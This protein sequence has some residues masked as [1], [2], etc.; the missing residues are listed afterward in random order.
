MYI[1]SRLI[2]AG[3]NALMDW[4]HL[5][6]AISILLAAASLLVILI[7]L[8]VG[9]YQRMAIMNVVWPLTA[10]YGGPLAVLAYYKI[11]RLSTHKA[12]AHTGR[13]KEKK[14]FWQSVVVGVTHCGSGCTLGDL[15]AEWFVLAVPITF[16]GQKLFGSWL[17]DFALAFLFGIAFQY[18]SIKP[19]RNLSLSQGL[20]AAIKADALS[21]ASWQA[22]MYGWMAFAIFRIFGH[23]LAK[24]DTVFWFMMQIAMLVGFATAFPVNWWLIKA[25]IKEE[26]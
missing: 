25:G 21:L 12:Q 15:I 3:D 8:L 18:F 4:L 17:L 13:R 7:D 5:T 16:L 9:N 20:W 11:G 2:K 14:P 24:T 10:L 1:P 26:M 19:M 23:E 22:G 6:A